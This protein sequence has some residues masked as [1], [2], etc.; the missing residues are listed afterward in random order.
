[1]TI[2]LHPEEPPA[3][4]WR[5]ERISDVF[6]RLGRRAEMVRAGPTIVAIDG[7][8]ASGKSTLAKRVADAIPATGVVHTDD[9]AWFHS[10]FG[11]ADLAVR[12]LETA[13]V[14]EP[15][16]FRPP[17][18]DERHR[19]GAIGLPSGIKLLLFEGVG[20]SRMEL[21]HLLDGR[22]W[23]QADRMATDQRDDERVAAG[24]VTRS[25]V[26]EWM[27]EELPFVAARLPWGHADLV[28]A[29]TPSLPH[30]PRTEVVVADGPLRP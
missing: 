29:G 5:V 25:D 28:L 16:S 14:G 20:S 6:G 26:E 8:S 2:T 11:W 3:G 13:R 12:V 10:R 19:Q 15:L 18:W 30:D 21:A 22:L 4:P 1:V 17:A 27:A 24:E 23:V 7:R 9:I